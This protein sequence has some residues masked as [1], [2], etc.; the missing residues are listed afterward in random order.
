[1]G[2]SFRHLPFRLYRLLISVS[3]TVK[4]V[5]I[6]SSVGAI[7]EPSDN[8]RVYTEVGRPFLPRIRCML[9]HPFSLMSQEDWNGYSVQDIET[10]GI[11]SEPTHKYRASKVKAERAVWEFVEKHEE[12]LNFE[13]TTIL[14]TFVRTLAFSFPLTADIWIIAGIRSMCVFRTVQ[15]SY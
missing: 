10:K 1:M 13:V 3:P 7:R 6:T 15:D 5:V 4:R 12:K 2:E 8:S 14:P 11:A 9:R